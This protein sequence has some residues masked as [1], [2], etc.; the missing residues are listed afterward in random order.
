[1]WYARVLLCQASA[2]V[3]SQFSGLFVIALTSNG[4]LTDAGERIL[5]TSV[6]TGLR[7]TEV[8]KSCCDYPTSTVISSEAK[9][10]REIRNTHCRR[11]DFDPRLRLGRNDMRY[12]NR[13]INWD[14]YRDF[15]LGA[16]D[17]CRH[18]SDNKYTT[19][20]RSVRQL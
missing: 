8:V 4:I 14:F 5:A 9:R 10:S 1:L 11:T 2:R 16:V 17:T 6:R 7:M 3:K 12:T 15:I 13:P 19:H 18:L 20:E